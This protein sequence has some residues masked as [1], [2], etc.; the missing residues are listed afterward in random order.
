[1]T[2]S[3]IQH[4]KTIDFGVYFEN[5]RAGYIGIDYMDFEIFMQNEG[6]KHS[7]VTMSDGSDRI[8]DS[9]TDTILSA[10]DLVDKVTSMMIIIVRSTES[11][12]PITMAELQFLNDFLSQLPDNIDVTWGMADDGS[13]GNGVRII[14]FINTKD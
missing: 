11:N 8:R 12:R 10:G 5:I 14:L 2:K 13:L 1:M 3:I 9:L 7:F 6:E 4:H